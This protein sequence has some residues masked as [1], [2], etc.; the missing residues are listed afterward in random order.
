[1]K[2]LSLILLSTI[3]ASPAL[4][5]YKGPI[6]SNYKVSTVEEAKKASD[7]TQMLLEGHI[8]NR[9]DDENYTFQDKTGTILIEIDKEDLPKEHFNQ[10]NL[11]KI[12]GEVEKDLLEDAEFEVKLIEIVK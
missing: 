7:D 6:A 3:I 10:D 2:I 9:I 5:D 8:I 4:A 11:V 12:F 1:M